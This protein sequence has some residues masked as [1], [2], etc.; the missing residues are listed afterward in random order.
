[1]KMEYIKLKSLLLEGN[2]EKAAEEFLSNLVKGTEWEDHVYIAG[3]YV[4]DQIIGIDAKDIDLVVA[5]PEGGI[6]FAEWATK[7]MGNYKENSNPVIYPKFGTAKFTLRGITYKGE[8]LDG[9]DIE[10]V[11]TRGEKYTSGSRKPEVVFADLAADVNRRDATINSLL[12]KLSTGEVLDLTGKGIDDIKN[13]IVRTPIDPDKTFEDDPLRI[14]RMVRMS[15]KY[16]WKIPM[17]ILRSI[18]K[19]AKELKTIS[20]ERI[21]DEVNKMILTDFPYKAFRLMQLLGIMQYVFPSLIQSDLS[22][23][24]LT[25]KLKKDLNLRLISVFVHVPPSKVQSELTALRYSIDKIRK[26]VSVVSAI[27]DFQKKSGNLTDEDL[28]AYA[29]NFRDYFPYLLDYASIYLLEF[30][31][32]GIKQRYNALSKE[33]MDN[34]IPVTGADLI[35][36]G[37]RPGPKFKEI[38][39]VVKSIYLKNPA[40]P[41]EEYLDII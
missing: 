15:A 38:L 39:D 9:M 20:K 12:K 24:K 2:K 27:P 1:M 37:L 40:T 26:V 3:G 35:S 5:L 6:K 36:M 21:H 22:Q 32:H 7:K 23:M 4:R 29:M 10:A 30:D 18:K 25:S 34:P 19:M 8:N 16:N 31:V 17:D 33:L 11:M 14:L 41:K 28:R 13:G